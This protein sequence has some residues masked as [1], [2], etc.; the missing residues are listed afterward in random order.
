[1]KH[2]QTI[3]IT[4]DEETNR[5][6]LCHLIKSFGYDIIT[7]E[8]GLDAIELLKDHRVDL[9]LL[10]IMMPKMGGYEV[11]EHIKKES[12]LRHIPTIVISSIDEME[13]VVKC[14]EMGA[15]D[16]LSKP[17]NKTLLKAR[18]GACLEKKLLRD[19]ERDHRNQIEK[20]LNTIQ[21][22]LKLGSTIQKL[23]LTNEDE[24]KNIFKNIGFNVSIFNK[25]PNTISGDFYYP[26]Y[27]DSESAGIFF[28]DVCGHGISAALISMRVLSIVS[29]LNSPVDK[30]SD[31]MEMV[32]KDIND[33][34]PTG[35]FVAAN[36]LILKQ[37]GFIISNAAQ[38]YPFIINNNKIR[39]IKI[40]SM[41]LGQDVNATYY[42]VKGEL[43]P[44]DKLILYTDG[45]IEVLNK[46][47]DLYG[48]TRLQKCIE[49][50]LDCNVADMIE[51]IIKDIKTFS[52]KETFDDD[53]TIGILEKV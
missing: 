47:G 26:K 24:T 23:F 30:A 50:H 22:D 4:E 28:A 38:P 44:G 16:Y 6:I 3:L 18:I 15:E 1:M 19:Q 49:K 17:F 29:Q 51:C 48:E 40:D 37:D 2:T 52:D 36:Y 13:S 27:I 25:A 31:F 53:I 20:L 8:N 14:I 33:F 41:P 11:L 32:N 21:S 12:S 10:D 43:A 7:A 39:E 42:E 9:I 34:M 35:R 46:D 45:I 5:L